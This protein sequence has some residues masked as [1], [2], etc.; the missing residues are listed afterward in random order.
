[1]QIVET[2]PVARRRHHRS[3][4]VVALSASVLLG[5]CSSGSHTSSSSPTTAARAGAGTSTAAGTPTTTAS[6]PVGTSTT[7]ACA[8][9]T[10]ADAAR[11]TGIALQPS[12]DTGGDC[13][14][15]RA[16][17]TEHLAVVSLHLGSGADQPHQYEF[18]RTHPIGTDTPEDV[19]GVG[20]KAYFSPGF[21]QLVVLKGT[22][23]LHIATIDYHLAPTARAIDIAIARSVLAKLG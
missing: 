23:L 14:W 21:H 13:S 1:V 6:A 9:F 3:V 20:D 10:Q 12:G 7:S 5:A 11:I 18:D 22:N 8:V 17:S 2:T 19:S 15:D 16:D 4:A